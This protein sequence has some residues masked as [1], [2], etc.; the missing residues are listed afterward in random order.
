MEPHSTYSSSYSDDP[1]TS[2]YAFFKKFKKDA[3]HT[4]HSY[5]LHTEDPQLEKFK[6]NSMRGRSCHSYEKDTQLEKF[7]SRNSMG[8]ISNMVHESCKSL[9]TSSLVK[10]V[11]PVNIHSFFSPLPIGGPLENMGSQYQEENS[12]S[13]KREKLRQWAA[14]ASF[15]DIDELCSKGCDLV[16]TLLSRILPSG[17]EK[18]H[19]SGPMLKQVDINAKSKSFPFPEPD[20]YLK[21]VHWR[22][23]RNLMESNFVEYLDNGPSVWGCNGPRDLV[24]PN[25][26]IVGSD[27]PIT[28]CAYKNYHLY[29]YGESDCNLDRKIASLCPKS[30]SAFDF[31]FKSFGTSSHL[32]QLDEF[33]NPNESSLQRESPSLLLDWDFDKKDEDNFSITSLDREMNMCVTAPLSWD[34]DHRQSLGNTP[35][36]SWL[37]PSTFL[38]NLCPGFT[39]KPDL[40][41]A[42]YCDHDFERHVRKDEK[43][44]L[45]KLDALPSTSSY[46]LNNYLNLE[47]HGNFD[48]THKGSSIFVAQSNHCFMSKDFNEKQHLLLDA[49]LLSSRFDFDF[50]SKCVGVADSF[51]EHDSYT[52]RAPNPWEEPTCLHI[53]K[54]EYECCPGST[55]TT[56]TINHFTSDIFDIHHQSSICFQVTLERENAYPTLLDKSSWAPDGE[57]QYDCVEDQYD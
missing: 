36:T 48:N 37:S 44:L 33:H 22:H 7:K 12:F 16:S 2:E 5:P 41:F 17:R 57:I 31:P 49:I 46:N 32:K 42:S 15:P 47:E 3:G 14:D 39:P 38:S 40:T 29:G 28:S 45:A 52:Y 35:S 10:N 55:C 8:D 54:D 50:G 18:N 26:D 9:K 43:Y 1:K 56:E 24:L 25:W 4:F 6:R 53:T 27:C 30:S 11:T 51:R 21:D 19:H 23:T 20:I 13:L 34:N